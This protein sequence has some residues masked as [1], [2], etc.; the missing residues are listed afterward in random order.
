MTD[1]SQIADLER[2]VA[3]LSHQLALLEDAAAIRKLHHLYGYFIDKCLYDETV[4]LFADNGV[5]RFFGGIWKGKESVRRLYVG[6][7]RKNFTAD[8]NGPVDGF[9]LDHMQMQDVIDVANDRRTAKARIRVFMAAGRH[10][11]HGGPRQ[12]WEGGLYENEYVREDGVWKISLLN[13]HPQWHAD[14]ATGWAH[15]KP[16]Y[17]PFFEKTVADGEP[18]G[19]DEI[20]KTVW[21]WPQHEVLPFH[22][23]HPVTGKPITPQKRSR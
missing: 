2:K 7:F 17:L 12:W 16:N 6:R 21:L 11:D 14:Y 15:T 22:N 20:D 19:P 9:L 3:G 1:D 13:Y 18:A 5:V 4:D 8:H 23:V 10:A